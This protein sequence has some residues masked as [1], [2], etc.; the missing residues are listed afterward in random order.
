MNEGA[1]TVN[2]AVVFAGLGGSAGIPRTLYVTHADTATVVP[3]S[4]TDG[5]VHNPDVN[6]IEFRGGWRYELGHY[7]V[8]W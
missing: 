8:E 3:P 1:S 2:P 5:W 6:C 7:V 4:E